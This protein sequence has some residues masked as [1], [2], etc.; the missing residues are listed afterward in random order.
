MPGTR[1][2]YPVLAYPH[3]RYVELPLN[4]F[5]CDMSL[6]NRNHLSVIHHFDCPFIFFIF[7]LPDW[8]SGLF[9][10]MP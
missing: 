10:G 6:N 2:V 9:K 1:Q 5:A 3:Y 7:G 8:I 4:L